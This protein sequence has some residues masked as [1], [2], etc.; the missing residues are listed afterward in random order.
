MATIKHV[1]PYNPLPK[2][3]EFLQLQNN[4]NLYSGAFGAGKSA[5]IVIAS[6]LEALKYKRNRVL[7]CRKQ[8]VDLRNTTLKTFFEMLPQDSKLIK[9]YLK[10][11]MTLTLFNG[12]EILFGGL[13]NPTKWASAELGCWAMDEATDFTIE[14]FNMLK[15]R[16]RRVGVFKYKG[17]LACNPGAKGHWIF[18]EFFEKNKG[19]YGVVETRSIDN[20]Y[21]PLETLRL[22]DEYRESDIDYYN[23][24]ILG[25][26]GQIEGLVYKEFDLSTNVKSFEINPGWRVYRALDWGY[27]NPFVCLWI[28]VDSDDNIFI[29]DEIYEKR[30]L[31]PD[32]ANIIKSRYPAIKTTCT[33]ADPSG[34]EY[35]AQFNSLGLPVKAAE[36]DVLPGIME[37]KWKM[38]KIFVHRKCINTIR[39]FQSYKWKKFKSGRETNDPE[40]PDKI[41][42]HT[43]DALRYFIYTLMPRQGRQKVSVDYDSDTRNLHDDFGYISDNYDDV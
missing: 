37:V 8:L 43:M 35:I 31:I 29:F 20:T 7:L 28:G 17:F 30:C 14:D 4:I 16:L 22:Y 5:T 27:E 11:E 23:R 18:Q 15:S 21:L 32:L 25:Q 38:D 40:V 33:V 2:Q 19:R 39:E 10:S 13:D 12:S 1:F 36:N 41:N 6:I 9:S 3:K 24:Y 26:W 42:D 34:A